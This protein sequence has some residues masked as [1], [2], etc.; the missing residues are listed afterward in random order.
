MARSEIACDPAKTAAPLP[1][2]SV[3]QPVARPSR[4]ESLDYL[5]GAMACAVMFFH[6]VSW[7]FGP[8][9]NDTVLGRLGIYAVSS[10][11]VLSGLSLGLAYRDRLGSLKDLR[12]YAIKRLFRIVPLYATVTILATSL[13]LWLGTR[14]VSIGEFL[15]NISLVFGFIAPEMAI[16]TGGWSIGNEVVFYFFF[17]AF[18]LLGRRSLACFSL[19]CALVLG[20]HLWYAFSVID[21]AVPLSDQWPAYVSVANQLFLFVAGIIIS[22]I[23]MAPHGAWLLLVIGAAAIFVLMPVCNESPSGLVAGLP[24]AVFTAVVVAG[25]AGACW[26]GMRIPGP[27]GRLLRLIGESC[28]AI[29][30]LHPLIPRI[31][32]KPLTALGVEGWCAYALCFVVTI[33]VS[34]ASWRWLESP[35]MQL[36]NRIVRGKPSGVESGKGVA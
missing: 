19:A 14:H 12:G 11:Y 22:R 16:P 13:S 35:M 36:G 32:V 15:L 3:E 20:L 10:F 34:I 2:R 26:C 27:T 28:Y 23:S 9:D 4:V 21:P 18:L 17:P 30:L 33:V 31:A 1:A 6:Y 25:V 7:G 29:Y 5:R 24:R 8:L